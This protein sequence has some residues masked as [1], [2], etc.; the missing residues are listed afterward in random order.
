MLRA[1]SNA[2]LIE[3]M[4][5]TKVVVLGDLV[6]DEYLYGE[7]ERVSRE[8]P[9]L[10]VRHESTE[11]KPGG[12]AN[13]AANVAALGA[14]VMPVGVVGRD[15]PGRV[16]RDWFQAAGARVDGIVIHPERITETKTRILA[17]GRS[18]TRQQMLRVDRA[19]PRPLTSPLRR[20]LA[21]RLE[22]A[23]TEADALIV[24]DYGSGLIDE[25][26]VAV[27]REVARR[28]PVCVDSRYDLRRYKGLTVVKPNEPELEAAIGRPLRSDDDVERAGRAL[29]AELSAKALV[30]TRGRHGMW[31]FEPAHPTVRIPVFGPAEAI[32]VTGAGD[33]VL[34]TFASALGAGASFVE[35]A[36]LA[37]VAGGIV[38]QKPGTATCTAAE[39]KVALAPKPS[40]RGKR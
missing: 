21:A 15:A 16:L 24:S 26:L 2:R 37:N 33:T 23:C 12:A 5:R 10:I 13:A 32:D 17:G 7:T 11:S 34:A 30:V 22:K 29:L 39:L 20:T 1:M 3:R 9:V 6:V 40:T 35:A 36:G 4:A 14:T 19:D 25:G 28:I 38:V 27:A 31:V 18:T 8:A